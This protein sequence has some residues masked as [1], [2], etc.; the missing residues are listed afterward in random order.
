MCSSDLLDTWDAQWLYCNRLRGTLAI[1]PNWNLITNLGFHDAAT[2][3]RDTTHPFAALPL[4]DMAFPLRHPRH[5]APDDAADLVRAQAEFLSRR[6]AMYRLG[7][8]L[9]NRHFYGKLLRAFPVLGPM[10][11]RLRRPANA[12]RESP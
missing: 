11:A 4:G 10:W 5:M 2:H 6:S 1:A 12:V 7:R 9:C 3:T 8:R